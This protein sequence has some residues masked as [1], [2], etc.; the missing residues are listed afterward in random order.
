MATGRAQV[1]VVLSF[2][3][4]VQ[5]VRFEQFPATAFELHIQPRRTDGAVSSRSAD[6]DIDAFIID[7]AT[8]QLQST[9]ATAWKYAMLNC[10]FCWFTSIISTSPRPAGRPA[11]A[12]QIGRASCRERV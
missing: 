2:Q 12:I 8:K 6:G 5:P 1:V 4:E 7:V 3:L 10:A 11:R 9:V